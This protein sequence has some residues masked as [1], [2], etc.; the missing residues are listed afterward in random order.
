MGGRSALAEGPAAW[1]DFRVY[2][3]LL[4][5]HRRHHGKLLLV[6]SAAR[7]AVHL[8]VRAHALSSGL[9]AV[10]ARRLRPLPLRRRARRGRAQASA[11]RCGCSGRRR[12]R[13][14]RPERLLHG[15][16]ADRRSRQSRPAARAL[17][18]A[19]R[20]PHHQAA[21][22]AA[23]PAGAG[24]VGAL[25]HHRSRRRRPR[26]RWWRRRHGSTA[27]TSGWPISGTSCRCSTILQEHGNGMLFLQIPSAFYAARLVGL[28]VAVGLGRCRRSC[29]RPRSPR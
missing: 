5:V 27:P 13:L 3:D 22:R 14:H 10:D 19:V 24:G 18:R 29:L 16:A 9:R 7:P 6:V 15:R 17:R 11:L 4:R 12:Q 26:P 2:N 23:A 21:A 25:A 1:F 8:A 28:P 20:H